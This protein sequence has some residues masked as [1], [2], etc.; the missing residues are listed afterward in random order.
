MVPLE[1]RKHTE[2]F[3]QPLHSGSE[4][5]VPRPGRSARCCRV[6]GRLFWLFSRLVLVFGRK[7]INEIK[8]KKQANNFADYTSEIQCFRGRDV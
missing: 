7:K 3:S 1:V 4:N 2:V 5:F 6:S 8:K